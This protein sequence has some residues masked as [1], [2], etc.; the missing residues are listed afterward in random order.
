MG[1]LCFFRQFKQILFT[2]SLLLPAVI[3][4]SQVKPKAT[5]IKPAQ[6]KFMSTQLRDFMR[7]T[8]EADVQFTFPKGFTETHIQ[9]N[10]YYSFDYAMEMPGHGFEMWLLVRSQKADWKSYV[11]SKNDPGKQMANPDTTYLAMG[12]AQ[13][14][15]FTDDPN[16]VVRDIKEEVL[17]KY[18]ASAGKSYLLAL[19][20]KRETRRYKY[21]LILTIEKDHTGTIL[22]VC[23][24]NEKNPDFFNNINRI[25]N[26]LKFKP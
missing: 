21:A 24:T 10:E 13:V 16:T 9:N 20:D 3:A 5:S 14:R 15:T 1:I 11:N 26:Y 2:A 7:R 25:S 6:Q 8:A 4:I 17:A 12:L 23:F 22:A 18:N 19:P